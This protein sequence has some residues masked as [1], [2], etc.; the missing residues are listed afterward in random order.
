MLDYLDNHLFKLVDPD[1]TALLGMLS[2]SVIIHL[3]GKDALLLAMETVDLLAFGALGLWAAWIS[4]CLSVLHSR[5]FGSG[6]AG[7]APG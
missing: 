5:H 4:G 7:N 6:G 3:P 1:V 2:G